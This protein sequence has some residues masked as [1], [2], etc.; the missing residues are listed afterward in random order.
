MPQPIPMKMEPR[1]SVERAY[2]PLGQADMNDLCDA[3]D[4]AILGGGGFGWL[5]LPAREILE[6]FW[7]GVVTMPA[8]TLILARM[9]GVVCGACQLL[10]PA[11]NNE[12]QTHIAELRTHFVSP[13][14]RGHGL[15]H[16]LLR[17]AEVVA[18]E[19]GASVVNLDVRACQGA[20]IRLYEDMGYTRIGTHPAYARVDGEM[21]A[22][23]YYYKELS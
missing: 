14:A 22:G 20:A 3:T 4:L 17:E 9:D 10:R 21:I 1:P 16:D 18:R 7:Q 15:A 6:R 8:R 13:W 11:P 23:H 5:E 19:D 2:Q 12:A